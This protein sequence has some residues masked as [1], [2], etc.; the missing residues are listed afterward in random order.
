MIFYTYP[1][2][3]SIYKVLLTGP[4][5]DAN[6]MTTQ[7]NANDQVIV[8]EDSKMQ[9][10]SPNFYS[11][12]SVAG[13]DIISVLGKH[14]LKTEDIDYKLMCKV[15]LSSFNNIEAVFL[16]EFDYDNFL[17]KTLKKN[18]VKCFFNYIIYGMCC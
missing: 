12:I 3:G 9:G 7:N 17:N 6:W 5:N 11:Y 18:G 4:N 13:F 16:L 15:Q 1:E 14:I 2:N 8:T 10:Q